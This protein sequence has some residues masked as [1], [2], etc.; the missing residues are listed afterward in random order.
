MRMQAAVLVVISYESVATFY[1]QPADG[2]ITAGFRKIGPVSCD[3]ID[4]IVFILV[5]F[6]RSG[7]LL[8]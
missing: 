7:L 3:L 2:D 8:R 4:L 5:G 1:L 6:G